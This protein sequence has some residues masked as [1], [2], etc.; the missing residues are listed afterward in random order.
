MA[1]NDLLVQ[2]GLQNL[3]VQAEA[4]QQRVSKQE[5]VNVVPEAEVE[6][7]QEGVI[8]ALSQEQQQENKEALQEKV[9]Q[10]N[11]HMQSLNRSLQFS[12]DEVSGETIVK[13]IDAETK[14]LVRQIPSQEVIDAR[15]AVEQYRGIL[16]KTKV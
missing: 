3:Q 14:E 7:K 10:L 12:I 15:N 1:N 5:P 6:A 4:N 8:S 9:A 13:V 16:L 11:D 2:S